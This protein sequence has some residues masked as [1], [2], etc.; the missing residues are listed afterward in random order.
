MRGSQ[1]LKF[2][3]LS[4]GLITQ[5]K[6]EL[7]CVYPLKIMSNK[8]KRLDVNIKKMNRTKVKYLNQMGN[9]FFNSSMHPEN[10]NKDT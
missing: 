8:S 5:Y 4:K 3:R 10:A 2:S 6:P 9:K 7:K 1:T